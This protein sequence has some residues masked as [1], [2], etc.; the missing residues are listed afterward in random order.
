MRFV[1]LLLLIGLVAG[2]GYSAYSKFSWEREIRGKNY[3]FYFG[4]NNQFQSFR[5]GLALLDRYEVDY[6][7]VDIEATEENKKL[8]DKMNIHRF[9]TC[10]LDGK[11]YVGCNANEMRY[12][13]ALAAGELEI[14]SKDVVLLS[15][16]RCGYCNATKKF[17]GENKVSYIEHDLDF[18][19]EGRRLL[20]L[21]GG[22]GVPVLLV[23]KDV[24]RGYNIQ[25]MKRVLKKA[26]VI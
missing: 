2:I 12:S 14:G 7:M 24:I 17:L 3:V 19:S 1:K 13:L 21:V 26:D 11:M 15:T 8:S 22:N 25:E 18:S 16:S 10:F 6:E 9:P 5:D 4:E 23:G 20:W